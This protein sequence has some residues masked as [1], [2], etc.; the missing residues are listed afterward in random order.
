MNRGNSTGRSHLQDMAEEAG[1]VMKQRDRTSYSRL[2]LEAQDYAI[3]HGKADEFHRAGFDAYWKDARDI[4]DIEV[5][6]DLAASVGL[7]TAELRPI[8]AE[9]K[10]QEKVEE[11]MNEAQHLNIHA[12]PT[13]IV[14]RKWAI[15]GA[16]PYELFERVMTEYVKAPKKG[17]SKTGEG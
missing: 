2:A 11:Q 9:R 7:D 16:Q 12:V 6:L 5:V 1:L 15:E 8:L 13:F 17:A 3:E 4:G 10:L 14:A